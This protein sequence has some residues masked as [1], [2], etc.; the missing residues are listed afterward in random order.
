MNED[1][2]VYTEEQFQ[3]D[4]LLDQIETLVRKVVREEIGKLIAPPD[5]G[6]GKVYIDIDTPLENVI[7]TKDGEPVGI[8]TCFKMRLMDATK[9]ESPPD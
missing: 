6:G 5:S 3:R 2:D 7:Y 4:I 8:C 1:Q 9:Q